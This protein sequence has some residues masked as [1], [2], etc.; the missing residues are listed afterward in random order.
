[1]TAYD[2]EH[3]IIDLESGE[4]ANFIFKMPN[5]HGESIAVYAVPELQDFS[6]EVE[7]VSITGGLGDITLLKYPVT[8]SM[9]LT[10]KFKIKVGK[11]LPP[12]QEEPKYEGISW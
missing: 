3:I 9:S 10:V 6:T 4:A 7:D 8:T 2:S 5:S 12:V 1:M 11:E